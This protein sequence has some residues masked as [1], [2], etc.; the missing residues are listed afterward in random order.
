MSKNISQSSAWVIAVLSSAAIFGLI[1]AWISSIRGTHDRVMPKGF[2]LE[3]TYSSE[4][5]EINSEE[6]SSEPAEN[7][8]QPQIIRADEF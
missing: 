1:L 8:D 5:N 4:H 7:K 2:D 6:L 3:R